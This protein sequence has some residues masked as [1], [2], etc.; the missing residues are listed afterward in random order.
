MT[1]RARGYPPPMPH[2]D[3][4]AGRRPVQAVR[5]A[6]RDALRW[7]RRA[8]AVP[9]H[10]RT[11]TVQIVKTAVAAVAAWVLA[12]GV[13][14]ASTAFLAPYTAVF[15]VDATVYRSVRTAGQ[16][17]AAVV[18]GVVIAGLGTAVLGGTTAALALVTPIGF[19]AGR[20]RGFGSGGYWVGVTALLMVTYGTAQRPEQLFSR[21]GI[22]ALGAGVGLAVNAVLFPPGYVSSSLQHA[23]SALERLREV[24]GDLAAHLRDPGDESADRPWQDLMDGLMRD[25]EAVGAHAA[26]ARESTRL[27]LRPSVRRRAARAAEAQ[28]IAAVLHRTLPRLHELI[29]ALPENADEGDPAFDVPHSTGLAAHDREAVARVIDECAEIAAALREGKDVRGQA[30]A[31]PGA[32]ERLAAS[33]QPPLRHALRVRRALAGP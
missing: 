3:A 11:V 23:Q 8:V 21:V 9:G 29:E 4:P 31:G 12:D 20:F 17:L 7:A 18:A 10:E 1:R 14:H 24:L 33:A 28:R 30:P 25:L 16:Q 22:I 27:N 32:G 15:M 26:D 5:A 2:S 13:L 6:C 19:A